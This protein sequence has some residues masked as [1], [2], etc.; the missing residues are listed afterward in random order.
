MYAFIH[1][2][3][4]V[5]GFV[6]ERD[7]ITPQWYKSE[8]I[9]PTILRYFVHLGRALEGFIDASPRRDNE[10]DTQKEKRKR[11]GKRF[12]IVPICHARA[13]SIVIDTY[14]L[15]GIMKELGLVRCGE[16]V[17]SAEGKV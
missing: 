16:K 12:D 15:H 2:H 4:A 8:S 6:E 7:G 1:E 17:F 10:E 5:L 3:R 11:I 13:Q 14:V 9:L